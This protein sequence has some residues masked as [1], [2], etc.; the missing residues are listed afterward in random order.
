MRLTFTTKGYDLNEGQRSHFEKKL[1]RLDKFF[2]DEVEA[3]VRIRTERN[4]E[5][6][7]VTIPLQGQFLRAQESANDLY[8][9]LDSVMDKLMGQ[10]RKHR[11]RLEKRMREGS[12][13]RIE[14][15]DAAIKAASA[16]AG[17]LV[18]TKTFSVTPMTP[19]DAISH[20]E[21]LGHTFFVFDNTQTN[22]ICVVY[23]RDDGNFGLLIPE[24]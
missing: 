24:K 20:M 5:I 10:I 1:S 21:M 8:G 17:M 19:E 22:S 11:T 16:N 15:E 13:A 2:D 14:S 7:E 3:T 9:S 23:T 6:V 18:R 4:Q 12:I